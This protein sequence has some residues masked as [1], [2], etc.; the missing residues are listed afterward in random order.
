MFKSTR[1]NLYV[2]IFKLGYRNNNQYYLQAKGLS[3]FYSNYAR[4]TEFN[5]KR[6]QNVT[7]SKSPG[8]WHIDCMCLVVLVC[9]ITNPILSVFS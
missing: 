7:Q 1:Y 3:V 2:Y 4:T 8:L 6:S 5:Y 9:F